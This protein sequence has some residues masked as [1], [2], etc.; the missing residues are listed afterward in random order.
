MSVPLLSQPALRACASSATPGSVKLGSP[1]EQALKSKLAFWA[2]RILRPFGRPCWP[3]IAH[4]GPRGSRLA[5]SPQLTPF[6][7][8]TCYMLL[9]GTATLLHNDLAQHV[10]VN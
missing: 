7:G 10:R 8:P 1:D 5:A 6:S 4:V 2:A 9:P 3:T